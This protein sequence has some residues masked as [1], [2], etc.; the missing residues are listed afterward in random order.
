MNNLRFEFAPIRLRRGA[1]L[2]TIGLLAVLA[3][4]L[5]SIPVS[6]QNENSRPLNAD[7]ISVEEGYAI[8][9]ILGNLS[10]PTTGIFDGNDL[11]VAESGWANTAPARVLRI[12]PDWTVQV[13]ADKGLEGPVTG[14]VMLNG[15]LYISHKGKVSIAQN[16]G[17]VRD[18]VTGLPSN[19]DHQNNNLVLGQDGKIYIGQG[20]TT[21]SAV[22]GEDNYIFGW[23][24][25]NP[26]AHEVPCYDIKLVGQNFETGNPLTDDPNDKVSTG[27]YKPFGTPSTPGEVIKGDVR[28]G[29]SILRFNP[30]GSGLEVFAW[31]LRNPFGLEL[32]AQGQLWAT[33][34]GA[35]VRGSRNIF[36]DPD[37]MVK[38]EQDAWYGWPEF[39]DDKPASDPSLRDPSK[40]QPQ[41]LWQ[42][43]PP[44]APIF[45]KFTT[46]VGVN[47]FAFSPGG[48]FGYAGDA[49]V[50][51]FGIYLPV[52]TGV[53]VRPAGFDVVR[54]DMKTGEIH[55]FAQ[56]KLPGPH[57]INRAGGFDRPSDVAF[58]PDGSLYIIDWGSSTVGPAGLKLVPLTGAV[59]RIYKTG[60]QQAVRPQGVL[61]I[62]PPPQVPEPLRQ[63]EVA[64]VPELYRML[65]GPLGLVLLAVVLFFVAL[66]VMFRFVRRNV[67]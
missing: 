14:L 7:A 11:L 22:V 48:A 66:A 62:T 52:T 44:R 45:T 28:C 21:N 37:Y 59:W 12:K 31:G 63:T 35:D 13:V 9:P 16:D 25:K 55:S 49:F 10:V 8:E 42:E 34:H 39:F 1:M 61:A 30:D 40:E 17:S 56:N 4:F 5:L 60:T 57:Y 26:S 47:G 50:A 3:V 43:H 41:F 27:A 18:I 2:R 53:N 51:Q 65:A 32:D 54:G 58:A 36:N 29:G 46:H 33:F 15:Q 20:T 19:G 6:A 38:V 67:R 23:L 24:Q 64:N